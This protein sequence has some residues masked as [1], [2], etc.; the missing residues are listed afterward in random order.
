MSRPAFQ[1][2]FR[3]VTVLTD[4]Q[5]RDDEDAKRAYR[6][7]HEIGATPSTQEQDLAAY[8]AV[9]LKDIRF[10]LFELLAYKQNEVH[11]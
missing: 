8:T 3:V 7:L 5:E 9:L 6:L 2:G 4:R 11:R 10:A 1:E